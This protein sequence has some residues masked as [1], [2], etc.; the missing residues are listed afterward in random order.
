MGGAPGSGRKVGSLGIDPSLCFLCPEVCRLLSALHTNSHSPALLTSTCCFPCSWLPPKMD[1]SVIFPVSSFMILQAL[2]IL[3]ILISL[4]ILLNVLSQCV[5]KSN[6]NKPPL[7]FHYFPIIGSTISYGKDPMVFFE[8]CKQKVSGYLPLHPKEGIYLLTMLSVVVRN[9]I[10]IHPPRTTRHRL[11][12]GS[13]KQLC[14]ERKA[15]RT[16]RRR[17]LC[18]VDDACFWD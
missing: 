1:S 12:R 5:A 2:A 11:S 7:V 10:H 14:V 8:R 18:A 3:I 17:S 6:G 9:C 15:Q 13:R 16:I 4:S